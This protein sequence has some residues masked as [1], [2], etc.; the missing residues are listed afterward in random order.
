MKKII[1]ILITM[2]MLI[3]MFSI[4]SLA[5][6][7]DEN[8]VVWTQ[9]FEGNHTEDANS[10]VSWEMKNDTYDNGARWSTA[11]NASN[12][13][14]CE[15]EGVNGSK[16]I[17]L[18][19]SKA[20]DD[21]RG[22]KVFIDQSAFE[23]GKTYVFK[24]QV[25]AVK[26]PNDTTDT[27]PV[28]LG[29]LKGTSYTIYNYKTQSIPYGEWVTVISAVYTPTASDIEKGIT[30]RVNSEK[31][32]F[33]DTA[34]RTTLYVDNFEILN[35]EN[36]T[37]YF[38]DKV[39]ENGGT[40]DF[41]DASLDNESLG[42]DVSIVKEFDYECQ[43]GTIEIT[44]EK[45]A[46]GN[47]KSLYYSPSNVNNSRLTLFNIFDKEE[48]LGKSYK[49]SIK[50]YPVG[51]TTGHINIGS[52]HGIAGSNSYFGSDINSYTIGTDNTS[53]LILNQWNTVEF[54]YTGSMSGS[55]FIDGI[56]FTYRAQG[57]LSASSNV[58]PYYI[59]DIVITP[60]DYFTN[61]DGEK[62]GTTADAGYYTDTSDES[63]KEGAI[64][65]NSYVSNEGNVIERYDSFGV[66]V[67]R[68]DD[69]TK[70]ETITVSRA[71]GKEPLKQA[72]GYIN[73]LI[74]GIGEEFFGTKIVAVPFVVMR[75]KT[76]WGDEFTY[77]VNDAGENLKYLG[78]KEITE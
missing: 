52:K 12:G 19:P 63:K 6:T 64:L 30:A 32:S 5:V 75:G 13:A 37:T 36:Y 65:I 48:N 15:N 2:T 74:E 43:S 53:K 49:V 8:S 10:N 35:L 28:T 46:N 16:C 21:S 54:T 3:G 34:N 71:D 9:D 17:K 58:I 56:V 72:N 47:G 14:F 59:D 61:T 67:Y 25:Y 66:W 4:T 73:L 20:G 29:I 60:I 50:I 70:E 38:E 41:N 45:D 44:D 40:I 78:T 1:A 22:G 39:N 23:E 33:T 18:Y 77:C 69:T 62:I 27:F 24:A 11:G 31:W 57:S 51:E 55:N 7:F 76:F 42:A 26:D 68:Q